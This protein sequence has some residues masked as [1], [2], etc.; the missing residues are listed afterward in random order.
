[1]FDV[2]GGYKISRTYELMFSGRNIANSFIRRYANEPGL[3]ISNQL[4]G[5]VWTVG[6]RG[7]F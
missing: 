1:M 5:A 4:Y 6:I 3:F 2:S 7:K